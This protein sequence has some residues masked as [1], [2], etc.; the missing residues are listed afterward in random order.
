MKLTNFAE[1]K[2]QFESLLREPIYQLFVNA[3]AQLFIDDLESK[4]LSLMISNITYSVA[5]RMVEGDVEFSLSD[6]MTDATDPDDGFKEFML[7][8]IL[9]D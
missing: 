9:A 7:L 4:D 3:F 1:I 2:K 8:S 5:C 6:V